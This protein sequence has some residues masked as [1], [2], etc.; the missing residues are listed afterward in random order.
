MENVELNMFN[1]EFIKLKDILCKTHR[2][3]KWKTVPE[4]LG[5]TSNTLVDGK[6]KMVYLISLVFLKSSLFFTD[7][8][9]TANDDIV[10][11]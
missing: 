2:N 4:S 7:E 6:S 5:S 3:N 11:L 9:R 8:A 1:V 10:N